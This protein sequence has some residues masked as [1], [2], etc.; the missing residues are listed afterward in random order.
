MLRQ[1]IYYIIG[2][3]DI[4]IA[5]AGFFWALVGVTVSLLLKAVKRDVNDTRTPGQFSWKFFVCDNRIRI[6]AGIIL[7]FVF[8][9][10]AKEMIGIE[11]TIYAAFIVGALSDRLAGLLAKVLDRIA[12]NVGSQ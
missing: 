6:V 5:L 7:V 1:T 9:R 12:N 2:T 10:F 4:P 8:M 3:E 11:N